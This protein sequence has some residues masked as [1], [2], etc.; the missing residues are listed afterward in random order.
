MGT[1]G[2]GKRT[3]RRRSGEGLSRCML[4]EEPMNIDNDSYT[5]AMRYP[6]KVECLKTL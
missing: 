2:L 6:G 1:M 5:K 4:D 3:G